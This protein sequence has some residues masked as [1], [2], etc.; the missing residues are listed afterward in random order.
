VAGVLDESYSQ[1]IPLS[2]EA[3]QS[4]PASLQRLEPGT[5]SILCSLEGRYG[6]SAER[7]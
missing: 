6:F 5:V 2:G 4:R 3:V 7:A 1:L